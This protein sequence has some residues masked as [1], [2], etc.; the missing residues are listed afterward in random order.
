MSEVSSATEDSE[1]IIQAL[2]EEIARLKTENESVR[3]SEER[4][5]ALFEALPVSLYVVDRDGTILAVNPFHLGHMG[6]GNTTEADYV[7]QDIA[8]RKSIVASGLSPAIKEVLE[9]TPFEAN[10]V[11]FP[12]LSGGG[13]GWF[14][15]RGVPLKKGSEILGAIYISEDVT[16]LKRAK[17][18]LSLH[19]EKLEEL[20]EKRTKD[21]R[22]ALKNV[23][24][25]SGLIPICASC[26]KV[27][28]DKGYWNQLEAYLA[29]HSEMAFS[30]GLC[31]DCARRLYPGIR[32]ED[33]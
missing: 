10:E 28:D 12:D 4:Y 11:L 21:L 8:T 17:D 3:V 1:T 13:E 5:R 22:E 33:P 25:L 26:R 7:G 15:V 2:K 23:K 32:M 19:K 30:H 16:V 14:N 18:E 29:L 24:T 20:V 27:R 31:P 6:R 9:G